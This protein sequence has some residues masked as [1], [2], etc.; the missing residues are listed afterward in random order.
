MEVREIPLQEILQ[1]TQNKVKAQR[2]S[3]MD[4]VQSQVSSGWK[5]SKTGNMRLHLDSRLCI[6]WEQPKLKKTKHHIRG[7]IHQLKNKGIPLQTWLGLFL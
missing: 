3:E 2:T 1:I 5:M 7:Y 4:T 6:H